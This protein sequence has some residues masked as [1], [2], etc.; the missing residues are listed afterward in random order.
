LHDKL[1]AMKKEQSDPECPPG[2]NADNESANLTVCRDPGRAPDELVRVGFGMSAFWIDRYE[3]ILV[4]TSTD[5]PADPAALATFPRNGQ[6]TTPSPP[7]AARSRKG[8]NPTSGITWFQ[9]NEACRASGK[10]LPTGDEWLAA[11]RGTP[12]PGDDMG[13]AGRCNTGGSVIRAT[14]GAQTGDASACVSWFGAEDMIGNV[15]ELTAEWYAG[16]GDASLY[17]QPWPEDY[18][19]GQDGT[20][21]VDSAPYSQGSKALGL[22]AVALRGGTYSEGTSAG[23]FAFYVHTAPSE[24]SWRAGFRCAISR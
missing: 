16:V 14:G 7:I 2:Y 21:N 1:D 13:V 10:R 8:V 12:D 19:D 20:L 4:L 9:A 17:A 23:L 3:A 6:W 15:A 5:S 22:P 18:G 24:A 11:A